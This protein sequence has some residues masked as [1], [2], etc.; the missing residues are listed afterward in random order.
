LTNI[1]RKTTNA[2][3]GCDATGHWL[4]KECANNKKRTRKI[5]QRIDFIYFKN[6]QEQRFPLYPIPHKKHFCNDFISTTAQ[7]TFLLTFDNIHPLD[8]HAFCETTKRWSLPY[9]TGTQRQH[10]RERPKKP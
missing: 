4:I 2:I 8:A 6:K 9:D 3:T 10:F 5:S 1:L 7:I